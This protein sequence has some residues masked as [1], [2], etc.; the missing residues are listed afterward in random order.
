MPVT[1]VWDDET[2]TCVRYVFTE[3]WTWAEFHGPIDEAN[4]MIRTQPHPVGII[5][6]LLESDPLPAKGLP[7]LKY[8]AAITP[9]NACAFVIV[10]A[11]G[12]IQAIARV[13]TRVY[14]GLG[15]LPLFADTLE[16]ARAIVA[17][18][19]ASWPS[20]DPK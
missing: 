14:P 18:K 20:P 8:M 1:V 11:G 3:R 6:D 19:A 12:F 9:E 13:F 15:L 17:E 2:H 4:V 7:T 16:A 5:A 10:G